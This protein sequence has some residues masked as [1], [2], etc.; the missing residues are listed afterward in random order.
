MATTLLLKKF[1]ILHK[2]NDNKIAVITKLFSL[3][4]VWVPNFGANELVAKC[5]CKICIVIKYNNKNSLVK[6]IYLC[7]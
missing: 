1:K 5:F 4:I 2:N 7:H 6:T 3:Q